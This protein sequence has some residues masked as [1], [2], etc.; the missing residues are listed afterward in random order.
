MKRELI[1][2][3]SEYLN[4]DMHIL[5]HGE[6]GG[7]PMVA[8]PCQDGMCD[9]WESFGMQDTIGDFIENGDV[10]LFS[11]DTVDTES[12]SDDNGDPGHRSWIQEMYYNYII[13][14]ALPLIRK[15]N[16]TDKLPISIGFSLG[17]T[18][19]AIVA[20]RRPDLFGCLLGCSGCYDADFFWH[21]YSDERVFNN[22]P[23]QILEYLPADH[24]YIDIYKDRKYVICV[25]QGRWEEEGLRTA[26]MLERSCN[27]K[28]IN[29]WIDRWGYD[30]DHDWPWWRVE[31][32]YYLPWF[33]GQTEIR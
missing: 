7:T 14:E 1:T 26:A 12:W 19:A 13:E 33:L 9:N 32:R 6:P 11:V 31:I 3:Y 24:P 21:G 10:Q 22:N 8:F 30:V 18:H 23:V 2:H 15:I 25:G 27:E 5:V 4:R 20:F 28:D 17:A 29:I 16:G